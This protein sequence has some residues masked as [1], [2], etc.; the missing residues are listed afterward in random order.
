MHEQ[1]LI[2]DVMGRVL[3]EAKTHEAKKVLKVKVKIGRL[4]HF[5]PGSFKEHFYHAAAGT[6]ASKAVLEVA[7]SPAQARC[8]SCK[9]EFELNNETSLCPFCLSVDFE[10]ISGKDALV[11]SVEVE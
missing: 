7:V 6:I 5:T 8:A 1:G 11:E 2:K 10:V 4:S 3:R 9:K